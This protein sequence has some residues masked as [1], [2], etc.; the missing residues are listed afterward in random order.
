MCV[1]VCG[2]AIYS[3]PIW[4]GRVALLDSCLGSCPN[5]MGHVP[6]YVEFVHS[7]STLQTDDGL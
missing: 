7:P 6:C 1:C 2:V 5:S 4:F 3:K